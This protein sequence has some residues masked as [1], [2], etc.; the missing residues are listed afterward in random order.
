MRVSKQVEGPSLVEVLAFT[1]IENIDDVARV[2]RSVADRMAAVR[3][4]YG[5]RVSA[6]KVTEDADELSRVNVHAQPVG[7]GYR[8]AAVFEFLVDQLGKRRSDRFDAFVRACGIKERVD[9]TRQIEGRYFSTRNR[10]R[11]SLDFGPLTN[12]LAV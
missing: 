6:I 2:E 4:W 3:G 5:W 12:T 11:T 7:A 10:G 9:D 1:M 8:E